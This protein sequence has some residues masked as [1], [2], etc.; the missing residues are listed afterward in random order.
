[1]KLWKIITGGLLIAIAAAAGFVYTQVRAIDVEQLS[2]DL[3][4][5]RGFG[6]NTAVL[7]TRT[8]AVIVD[9]MTF[10]LQGER[11]RDVATELTG[12]APVMIINTH[13]HF[14]HTHGNPA[15][16]PGTRVLATERTLA[17]L[18]ALD[19]DFWR[20]SAQLLPS[21]TFSDR[22]IL[23]IGGKN[24]E[25][26]HP[27]IGHTDGDL[28]VLFREEGVVHMGDLMFNRH[29]PNIDLEAGG[30]VQAWPATLMNVLSLDFERVI[31]G[32]GDTTDRK[33]LREFRA[34]L[35]QLGEIGRTAAAEG[36]SLEATRATDALQADADYEPIRF[37]VSLGLDRGFVLQRAWEET[38]GNFTR[39]KLPGD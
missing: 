3:W 39:V 30:S 36:W 6:G 20:E 13:Y 21:E 31:P 1:M 19:A 23:S 14:D 26:I 2:P 25:L 38:T 5:L 15:F 4:V 18:R 29:Y 34:F 11:I 17:Y 28:V 22:H 24:L 8:G 33:G 16:E 10:G 12:S 9:T 7:R 37:I 27:G 32:H 35:L